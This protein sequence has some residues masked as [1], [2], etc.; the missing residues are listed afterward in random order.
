MQI[1]QGWPIPHI[2]SNFHP[3]VDPWDPAI[4]PYLDPT[5]YVNW[6]A[7]CKREYPQLTQLLN[8]YVVMHPEA[9]KN[10]T[11]CEFK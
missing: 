11:Y 1:A 10:G 2:R 7:D 8:G 4:L 5:Y 6:L 9:K 3:K